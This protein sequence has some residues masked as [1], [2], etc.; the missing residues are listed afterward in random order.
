VARRSLARTPRSRP[1]LASP[2]PRWLHLRQRLDASLC[3]VSR[4]PAGTFAASELCS[5]AKLPSDRGASSVVGYVYFVSRIHFISRF[6][7]S[8]LREMK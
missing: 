5:C 8:A 4:P 3:A 1:E 2:G 6:P 7:V